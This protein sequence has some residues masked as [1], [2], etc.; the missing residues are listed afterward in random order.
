MV[1]SSA[2]SSDKYTDKIILIMSEF[3]K[4]LDP[5]N[6]QDNWAAI[7]Y[8]RRHGMPDGIVDC[9]ERL[10]FPLTRLSSRNLLADLRWAL[11]YKIANLCVPEAVEIDKSRPIYR[12]DTPRKAMVHH[13]Y[14]YACKCGW[15]YHKVINEGTIG[16][17]MAQNK[18]MLAFHKKHVLGDW[19][20]RVGNL[21]A[22]RF[23]GQ[24]NLDYPTEITQSDMSRSLETIAKA[25]G[26]SHERYTEPLF[27]GE[28]PQPQHPLAIYLDC[29]HIA[30]Y[31]ENWFEGLIEA[32]GNVVWSQDV[33]I[34]LQGNGE[35]PW[36]LGDETGGYMWRIH[37]D[38]NKRPIC[39]QFCPKLPPFELVDVR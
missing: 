26:N 27:R 36:W 10:A 3:L 17:A 12:K 7:P 18:K 32:F 24:D 35:D 1:N 16:H 19:A 13:V 20:T 30:K 14:P 5:N 11:D 2:S 25:A 8:Y 6:P 22:E 37:R 38:E 4:R 28:T 21:I 33:D 9:V 39:G 31:N 23:S 34:A 29:L 15:K